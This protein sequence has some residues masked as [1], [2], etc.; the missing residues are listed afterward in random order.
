MLLAMT[1]TGSWSAAAW[2]YAVAV[3]VSLAVSG[4]YRARISLQ[5]LPEIPMLLGRLAVPGLLIMLFMSFAVPEPD[6]TMLRQIA[7]TAAAL[8]LARVLAYATIRSLRRSGSMREATVIVGAGTVGVELAMLMERHR[9]LG[10]EPIGF[11]DD[12]AGE[13]LLPWPHLG[14]IARLEGI[15]RRLDI[16]RVVVAFG[17]LRE[18][19]WVSIMRTAVVNDVEIHVVPRFFDVG[20]APTGQADDQIWGIPLC[21][22]RR[23]VLHS[24]AWRAKRVMDV[25]CS[26]LLLILSGPVQALIALAVRISSPGPI[27][28]RQ[29]RVGQH[30]HE[31]ELLKFRSMRVN[32]DGVNTWA[33]TTDHQTA[34]GR[35]LRRSSLDELPQLWNVLR[36]DMSLVGPRPERP[37]F[38]ARFSVDIPGYSDR[39]R[40]P[41]G[42]SGWAQ[43][44]GLRGDDTSLTERA[45]FDNF[46]IEGWSPWLDIVILVRT[47]GAMLKMA[48]RS[49]SCLANPET[50][51]QSSHEAGGR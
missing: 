40:L 8:S 2:L 26:G 31:F 17:R 42:L 13:D 7:A 39:H 4:G 20:M 18:A 22:V 32:H 24:W 14:P 33:A 23:S 30:G 10:L 47:A 41:V 11:L 1:A 16:D 19:D 29:R 5:A 35:W 36:G 51:P 27:L 49:S 25:A 37:Q 44:H 15:L 6:H 12:V 50:V 48:A 21:R 46:Y 9:E 43:V 34:V 38:A 45:R 3:L 28:Y